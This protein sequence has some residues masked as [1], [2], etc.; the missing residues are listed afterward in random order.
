MSRKVFLVLLISLFFSVSAFAQDD[1]SGLD[2]KLPV[3]KPIVYFAAAAPGEE[4]FEI[5]QGIQNNEFH[6]ESQ[7]LT[8]LAKETFE[9]GDYDASAGF[10]EEAIHYTQLS[11]QYVSLQLMGEARRLLDWADSNN[12]AN[13]YPSAYVE[14]RNYYEVSV[15]AHSNEEWDESIEAAI[16]SIE[17][18]AAFETG[19]TAPLPRQY[20]VRTWAS[21]R[22]CLWNIAGYPWVYGEPGRWRELY[23]ANKSRMPD[24]DNPNVIEPGMVLD[25][26]SIRGETRQGMWDSSRSY[27]RQ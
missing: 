2:M 11:D 26:P 4:E 15:A 22:D 16:A 3:F 6:R 1:L 17:L 21:A 9:Y 25:I 24:P 20:T 23:E 14:S 10:A 7:R 27:P 5:P 12:I 13:R 19:R 8:R 18:L